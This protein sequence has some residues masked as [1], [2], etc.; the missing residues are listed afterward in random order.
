MASNEIESFVYK[1]KNLQYAG[2]TATLTLEAE[3]GEAFVTLK[4]CLGGL[5]PPPPSVDYVILKGQ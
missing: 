5:P 1:F 2:Y 3:N 4:A